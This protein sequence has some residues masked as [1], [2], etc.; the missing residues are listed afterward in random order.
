M[1]RV[2]RGATFLKGEGAYTGKEKAVVFTVAPVTE[3]PR[4][5]ESIFQIDPKAFVVIN[6][7]MEVL[8]NR[9]GAIKKI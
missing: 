2:N 3:I 9:H 4:I 7:T 1:T 8:G 5:K 6:D